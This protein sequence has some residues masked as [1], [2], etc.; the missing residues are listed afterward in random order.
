[1]PLRALRTLRTLCALRT[2]PALC[3]ISLHPLAAPSLSLQVHKLVTEACRHLTR[4][5]E[6]QPEAS[7]YASCLVQLLAFQGRQVHAGQLLAHVAASSAAAATAELRLHWLQRHQPR[8]VA[9]R[10]AAAATLLELD[11]ASMRGAAELHWQLHTAAATA[12][13][14]PATIIAAPRKTL[15]IT[16]AL[17]LAAA[18]VEVRRADPCAWRLLADVLTALAEAVPSDGS[19]G[20]GGRPCVLWWRG[21]RDW[22]VEACFHDA[23]A[24]GGG[25][26]EELRRERTRT[27]RALQAALGGEGDADVELVVLASVV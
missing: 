2:P 8:E 3:T 24:A 14:A 7:V 18:H 9:A 19:G 23:E 5:L 6:R 20:S 17:P 13:A 15:P 4:A 11:P 26:A 12:T 21:V 25:S 16:L 27:A 1:M 10:G 22:W